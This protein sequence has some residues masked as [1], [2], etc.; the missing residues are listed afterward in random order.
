MWAFT[1]RRLLYAVPVLLGVSMLVFALIHLAPGDVVDILV[2]P[3]VPKEIAD[4]LRRR[5]RLDE[6]IYMQYLAWLGRLLV[7]DFGISFFTGRP[8]AEEL[9]G[10]LGNTLVLA[11]PAAVLGF[12]LGV[13][14]RCA[15]RLQSR[16]LA[17]Q[18]V[19]RDG[20]H[21]RQPAALL[22]RHR[23][24]RDLRRCSQRATGARYGL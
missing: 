18:A 22:G 5:F 13:A 14:A 11:L 4:S 16:H 2:P 10:A 15:G 20:D 8:V 6:P 1:L 19:L 12:S 21:R 7:G 3:E 24:G 9:F 23:A 17:R